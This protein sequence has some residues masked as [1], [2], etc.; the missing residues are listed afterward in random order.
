MPEKHQGLESHCFFPLRLHPSFQTHPDL[1]HCLL[2]TCLGGCTLERDFSWGPQNQQTWR[3]GDLSKILVARASGHHPLGA[4]GSMVPARA[5]QM[6]RL[7]G[8]QLRAPTLTVSTLSSPILGTQAWSHSRDW[9]AAQV[10]EIRGD[11]VVNSLLFF[12]I[13]W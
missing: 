9:K 5:N 1:R 7:R 11:K 8:A 4:L 2:L 12:K 3:L 6:V 10:R 13:S